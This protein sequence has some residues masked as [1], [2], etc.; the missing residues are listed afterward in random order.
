MAPIVFAVFR[1]TP[2][3]VREG[4]GRGEQRDEKDARSSRC[5]CVSCPTEATAKL[6]ERSLLELEVRLLNAQRRRGGEEADG[7][8]GNH[9]F[10]S[11]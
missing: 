9:C 10:R 8:T 6:E 7:D 5:P 2:A 3:R 1:S 4:D 11:A